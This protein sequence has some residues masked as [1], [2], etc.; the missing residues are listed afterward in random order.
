MVFRF[1]QAKRAR[2]HD[3][4]ATLQRRDDALLPFVGTRA[5]AGNGLLLDACVYID[6]MQGKTPRVVEDLLAIRTVNHSAVALQELLHG[7]GV[8]NPDD[9]RTPS[10]VTRIGKAVDAMK[11]HRLFTPDLDVLATAAVY[12]GMPSRT[13]GYARG[14]RMNLLHDCVLFLQAAKLG[15]TVL[16]RNVQDFDHLLQMRPTGRVLFYRL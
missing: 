7:V 2:R 15:F 16:T 1:A 9:P 3:P 14:N 8:L 10:V 6:Q 4:K 13:Q 12:A 11:P 5:T